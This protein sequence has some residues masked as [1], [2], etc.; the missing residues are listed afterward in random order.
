MMISWPSA[1]L[2][3]FV[4]VGLTAMIASTV[5]ANLLAIFDIVS[6]LLTT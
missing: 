4:I 2:F 1:I 5:T 6:P 3:G